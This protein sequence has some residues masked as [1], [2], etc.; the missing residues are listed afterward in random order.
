MKYLAASARDQGSF[1]ED[2]MQVSKRIVKS[3]STTRCSLSV[4]YSL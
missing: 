3:P 1:V 2:I 4:S